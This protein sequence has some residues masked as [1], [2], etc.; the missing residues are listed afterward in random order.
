MVLRVVVQV[1]QV[2][3]V[4]LPVEMMPQAAAV[5]EEEPAA[6]VVELLV[7]EVLVSLAIVAGLGSEVMGLPLMEQVAAADIGVVDPLEV[8]T[9]NP[10]PVAVVVL[11][12]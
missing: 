12:M 4:V 6:E 9:T 8:T 5:V 3:Q 11:P 1:V 10:E 7:V 2:V